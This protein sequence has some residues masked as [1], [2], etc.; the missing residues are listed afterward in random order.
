M[1]M[2]F[3]NGNFSEHNSFDKLFKTQE[4][5]IINFLVRNFEDMTS[6]CI[7]VFSFLHKNLNSTISFDLRR[8]KVKM[9]PRDRNRYGTKIGGRELL[10]LSLKLISM[11]LAYGCMQMY[12][13]AYRLCFGPRLKRENV[14]TLKGKV[15]DAF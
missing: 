1:G 10:L 14:R 8:E 9:K 2:L 13:Y 11:Q 7:A 3:E 15:R 6:T 5:R 12:E 4:K